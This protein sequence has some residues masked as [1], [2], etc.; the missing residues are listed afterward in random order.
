MDLRA[1]AALAQLCSV[2]VFVTMAR[3]YFVPWSRSQ[4]R[5]A[6][7][8][9]LVWVHAFRYVALQVYSAQQAGFPISDS[10]RDRI[11]YGDV[12]GMILALIALV[13]LR[14][15]TRWSIPLVWL[16]VVETAVDTVANVRGGI[17]EHLFGAANGVTWM[18]V[19]IYVPLLMV[20]LGLTIWQL[21]S[22]RGEPLAQCGAPRDRYRLAAASGLSS[23]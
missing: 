1:A 8:I 10:G 23:D 19:S 14:H 13:A 17:R 18:V 20:S 22:R 2:V 12:T 21:Y 5:A 3:W 11:V 16:V 4:D 7:L 15:R 9:P 6:A